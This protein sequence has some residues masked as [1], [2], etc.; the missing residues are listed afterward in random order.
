MT[1]KTRFDFFSHKFF[2]WAVFFIFVVLSYS[3]SVLPS[4]SNSPVLTWLNDRANSLGSVLLLLNLIIGILLILIADRSQKL[5]TVLIV[6][7][8]LLLG[9]W[10]TIVFYYLYVIWSAGGFV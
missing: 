1:K 8:L 10:E 2:L 3:V 6:V 4:E 5:L 7:I 9:N